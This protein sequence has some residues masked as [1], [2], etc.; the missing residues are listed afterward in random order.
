[1][2]RRL[3][4]QGK[5][6]GKRS[7]SGDD[8]IWFA[9]LATRRRP[10]WGFT[11]VELLVVITIIA[12]LIAILLPAIQSARGAARRSVCANN[13]RQ[14]GVALAGFH[15]TNSRYPAGS[16]VA[17]Q[18]I[19][20][21]WRVHLLP[22]LE[23]NAMYAAL[24]PSAG[25]NGAP[26][27]WKYAQNKEIAVFTCP[28]NAGARANRANYSGVMGAGTSRTATEDQTKCGSFY[29]DGLMYPNSAITEAHVKDGGSNTMA[30]AE[31]AYFTQKSWLY[32]SAWTGSP[33][34]KTCVYAAKNVSWPLNSQGARVGFSVGDPAVEKPLRRVLLNDLMFGSDHAAG[35]YFQFADGSVHFINDTIDFT[36]YQALATIAGGEVNTFSN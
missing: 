11:L 23:Q 10:A 5:R 35:A 1:M 20:I 9:R 16:E 34:K 27:G 12:M 8:C 26:A 13:L 15:A 32:G 19:S 24:D 7:A 3:K 22:Y 6:Q 30:I 2:K 36:V 33:T 17:P 21:G 14:I 28:A 31:R 18:G 4:R 25:P 29:T